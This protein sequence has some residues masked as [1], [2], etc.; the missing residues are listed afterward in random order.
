MSMDLSLTHTLFQTNRDDFRHMW[1]D[2]KYTM[3]L[4]IFMR[5]LGNI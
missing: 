2:V 1:N 3:Y 4:L 5:N